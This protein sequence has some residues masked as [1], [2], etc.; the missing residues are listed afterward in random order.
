MAIKNTGL[1]VKGLRG[2]FFA[3]FDATPTFFG[4]LATTIKSDS[5]SES[6]KWLGMVPQM[7][8]WGQGRLAKGI[9]SESYSVEN[10]KYESTLEIDR[11][12]VSDDQLGQIRIR[13][14][15]LA[16]RAA[17]HKDYLIS[18]LL[19]SGESA[20]FNA[21]DGKTFFATD[22]SSGASGSQ[23]N[24]LD[25]DISVEL[26]NEP[27]TPDNPGVLTLQK[28][29]GKARSAMMQ[30]KDD[31][32]EPMVIN[33]QGLKV[34]CHTD[35]EIDWLSALQ[36]AMVANTSNV[37]PRFGATVLP[38]PWLTDVSKFYLAWTGG[39]VRPFVLQ[40]RE[41]LEF[42]STEGEGGDYFMKEKFHAGVRARYAMTYGY[43]QYCVRV[44]LV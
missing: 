44:D 27:N 36:A 10:K 35:R 6:Y 37:L 23:S 43:W 29:F 15:E 34:V 39:V 1:N 31:V 4:D 2:D 21:Y 16:Q 9:R 40:D 30:F 11:D 12:E 19:S 32:G 13:L 7:R 14:Q 38:V 3:R 42:D 24:K 5:D 25:F 41:P 28:A 8:E 33:T 26:P 17:T 18:Q 20:G 22:H